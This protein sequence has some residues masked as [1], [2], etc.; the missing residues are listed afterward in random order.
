MPASCGPKS[1]QTRRE[2]KRNILWCLHAVRVLFVPQS[3]MTFI[4][5]FSGNC[6][7]ISAASV[8]VTKPQ[9]LDQVVPPDQSFTDGYAGWSI[10]VVVGRLSNRIITDRLRSYRTFAET[11]LC[12]YSWGE[13]SVLFE[14]TAVDVCPKAVRPKIKT[15]VLDYVMCLWKTRGPYYGSVLTVDFP[16]LDLI[17]LLTSTVLFTMFIRFATP[18]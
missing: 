13:A 2:M 12:K 17:R 6:W 10:F 5:F 14:Q 7:F 4:L 3:W 1:N 15:T 18:G 11:C 16:S 9:L 8:L